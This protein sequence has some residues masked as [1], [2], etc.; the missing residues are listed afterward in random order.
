MGLFW[1]TKQC[2]TALISILGHHLQHSGGAILAGPHTPQCH[3]V[4]GLLADPTLHPLAGFLDDLYSFDPAT[5]AWTLLSAAT[6]G[7]PPP[8]AR[9]SHGFTSAG[10]K[11]Y[12]HG[13]NGGGIRP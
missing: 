11:L 8:A 1:L 13:G 7:D 5:M 4:G 2:K 10:G 9:S 3:P 12:V 6:G